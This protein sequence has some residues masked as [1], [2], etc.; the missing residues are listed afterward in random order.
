MVVLL[1]CGPFVP[2][3]FRPMA[4]LSSG[5]FVRLPFYPPLILYYF[6]LSQSIAHPLCAI[7]VV[8]HTPLNKT[9]LVC[10]QLSFEAPKDVQLEMLSRRA[11]LS[12]KLAIRRYNCHIVNFSL[13]K[14]IMKVGLELRCRKNEKNPNRTATL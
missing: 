12:S 10:L 3:P 2:L 7:N 6:V 13:R 11:A 9:A 8:S 14:G 1:S 5:P 4:L